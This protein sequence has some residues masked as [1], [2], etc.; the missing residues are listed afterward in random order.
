VTSDFQWMRIALA[1][2]L[3][4]VAYLLLPAYFLWHDKRVAE[5][6]RAL[7]DEVPDSAD[8][9]QDSSTHSKDRHR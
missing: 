8:F 6:A 2:G 9:T 1:M 4:A 3:L 5:R 7:A